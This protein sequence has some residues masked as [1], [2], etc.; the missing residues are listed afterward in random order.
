MVYW[1]VFIFRFGMKYFFYGLVRHL[2]S[3]TFSTEDEFAGN[4]RNMDIN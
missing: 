3:V 1:R 2:L 4:K